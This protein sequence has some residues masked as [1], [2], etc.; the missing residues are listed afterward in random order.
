[1]ALEATPASVASD[2]N[3]RIVFLPSSTTA[4][5]SVANLSGGT[6]IPLTYSLT[7]DG[8]SYAKNENTVAD[9]RLTLKQTFDR[10]GT[11]TETLTLKYVY[12]DPTNDV[13]RPALTE[14]TTGFIVARFA[15]PNATAWTV[16]QTVDVFTILC[17]AQRK[18][19]P[20]ANGLFTLSQTIYLTSVTQTDVT[21]VA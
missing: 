19:A 3:L 9:P 20:A 6:A 16:G 21:T 15:I 5:K 12:G 10:P 11:F 8:W 13:A 4:P 2:G 18:D 17:G 7:A 14:G 1:M